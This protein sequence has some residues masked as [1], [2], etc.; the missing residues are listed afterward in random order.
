MAPTS[1][2]VPLVGSAVFV[3]VQFGIAGS[4]SPQAESES[5]SPAVLTVP[6]L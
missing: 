1:S 5:D 3:S 6:S 4:M 2:A